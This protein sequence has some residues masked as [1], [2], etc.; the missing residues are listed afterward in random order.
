MTPAL[1]LL[2]GCA[3]RAPSIHGFQELP[4]DEP[5]ASLTLF[6]DSA[7]AV[8]LS[9]ASSSTA[10]CAILEEDPAMVHQAVFDTTWEVTLPPGRGVAW[11]DDPT[12]QL[13]PGGCLAQRLTLG[14]DQVFATYGFLDPE[15]GDPTSVTSA[16]DLWE[17][18]VAIRPG[19]NPVFEDGDHGLLFEADAPLLPLCEHPALVSWSPETASYDA[20]VVGLETS[21][22]CETASFDTGEQL[23]L[24]H[25]DPLP[26][27]VDDT[28]AVRAQP[29][30]IEL[31]AASGVRW[32][33]GTGRAVQERLRKDRLLEPVCRV[34]TPCGPGL[35]TDVLTNDGRADRLAWGDTY[36]I[37]EDQRDLTFR[38]EWAVWPLRTDCVEN[39]R[40]TA[41]DR[42]HGTT[43]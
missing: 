13:T 20:T 39:V 8:Q 14:E 25:A 9:L 19:G 32:A 5:W 21:G 6:N 37:T 4:P 24:C 35:A 38:L 22:D 7:S 31:S 3:S 41:I 36:A 42:P 29:D 28:I 18:G 2:A 43:P 30:W 12:T 15:E 11:I 10:D 26:F 1:A 27:T 16:G 23:Q 34:E 17:G 33:H 40:A